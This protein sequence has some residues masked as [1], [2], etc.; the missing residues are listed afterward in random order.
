VNW[1]AGGHVYERVTESG[2]YCSRRVYDD[3]RRECWHAVVVG[4][5]WQW[6]GPCRDSAERCVTDLR[7]ELDLREWLAS[8]AA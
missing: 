5:G 2:V 8:R 6:E 7:A 4:N 1:W 3:I